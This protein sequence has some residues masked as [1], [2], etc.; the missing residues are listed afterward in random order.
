MD[1]NKGLTLV[2]GTKKSILFQDLKVSNF[3]PQTTADI[4]EL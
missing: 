3:H 2:S 1:Y 4:R